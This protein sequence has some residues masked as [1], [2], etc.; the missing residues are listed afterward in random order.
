MVERADG[1]GEI[2]ATQASAP[3]RIDTFDKRSNRT[4]Y[5]VIDPRT[6]WL[7][8]YD[9]RSNRTGYGY[10]TSPSPGVGVG[11]ELYDRQGNRIRIDSL[12]RP[13]SK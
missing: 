9:A 3:V 2:V 4:G 6:G 5:I 13:V 10:T 12:G 1:R 8:Q 7:D 11:P